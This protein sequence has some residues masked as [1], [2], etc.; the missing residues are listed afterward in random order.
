MMWKRIRIVYANLIDSP[1]HQ[2]LIQQQRD[3]LLEWMED[4]NDHKL[5]CYR[6]FDDAEV[7]EAYVIAKEKEATSRKKENSKGTPKPVNAKQKIFKVTLP[8]PILAGSNVEYV[9]N[10]DIPASLGAQGITITLKQGKAGDRVAREVAM[11]RGKGKLVVE[12][13]IPDAPVDG[14]S[15]LQRGLALN[16]QNIQFYHTDA[17]PVKAKTP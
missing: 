14:E 7:R 16:I 11:I 15:R 3:R 1:M 12:F 9:V 4:T 17:I 10:Y 2:R 13:K 5:D 8:T 6:H